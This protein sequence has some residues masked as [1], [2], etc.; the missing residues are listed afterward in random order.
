MSGIPERLW[1]VICGHWEVARERF[2]E[3][4]SLS[5]AYEDLAAHIRAHEPD[6]AVVNRSPGV[7]PSPQAHPPG[8]RDPFAVSY[9][10]LEVAPG[11]DLAGLD[12]PY[13]ARRAE[14]APQ[15]LP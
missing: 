7:L 6:P 9:E 13:Q 3:S 5:S 14:L 15:K 10:L 12:Q 1:H 11:L 8:R 2:G 4:E